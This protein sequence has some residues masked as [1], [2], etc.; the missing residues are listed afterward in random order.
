MRRGLSVFFSRLVMSVAL[1]TFLIAGGLFNH[2]FGGHD[3]HVHQDKSIAD[4]QHADPVDG[5]QLV[6]ELATVHCGANLLAMTCEIATDLQLKNSAP[7]ALEPLR[8]LPNITPVDPP[9]PRSSS[10]S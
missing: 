10:M 8:I 6:S 2:T 5:N 4:H 3:N 9:P 1:L 7:D